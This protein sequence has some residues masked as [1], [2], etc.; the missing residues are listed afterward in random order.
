MVQVAKATVRS[1]IL[2]YIR[3]HLC[4]LFRLSMQHIKTKKVFQHVLISLAQLQQHSAPTFSGICTNVLKLQWV[5]PSNTE[6]HID[7]FS[8]S[9]W[10][11]AAAGRDVWESYPEQQYKRNKDLNSSVGRKHNHEVTIKMLWVVFVGNNA[12]FYYLCW[13]RPPL[14]VQWRNCNSDSPKRQPVSV[15]CK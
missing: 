5:L 3:L 11:I 1:S 4:L 8:S 9:R 12:D 10:L 15:K 14:V 7:R 6:F 2:C 13:F